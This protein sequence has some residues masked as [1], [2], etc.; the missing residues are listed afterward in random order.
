MNSTKMASLIIEIL[1]LPKVRISFRNYDENTKYNYLKV[2]KYFTKRHRLKV[3]RNKTIGVMLIDINAFSTFDEYYK[4][5]NGKN[6]AAYYQRKA[7]NRGYKFIQIDRN[8]YIDD[9]HEINTSSDCRKGRKMSNSYLQKIDKF[10]N[11]PNYKYF[12]V[13][14]ESGKLLSYIC[15]G[16][17]GEFVIYNQLLGHKDFL[18]DGVMYLMI[19]E[20]N[21]L[22]FNEYKNSTDFSEGGGIRYIM[23]DT[24]FGAS[25][26]LKMFKTKLGFS[27]YKVKWI[28]GK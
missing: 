26:G 10:E 20:L 5:I 17:Y 15:L 9:I 23:Y 1:K 21:R 14:N 19:V 4:S 24:F 27:P 3:I 16:F 28:W 12:G 8:D 25:D 11:L 13:I 22:I 7:L 6:S 18:N 2:Y